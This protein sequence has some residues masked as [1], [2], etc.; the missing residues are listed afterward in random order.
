MISKLKKLDIHYHYCSEEMVARLETKMREAG[1]ELDASDNQRLS[2]H[3]DPEWRYVA[4]G[5]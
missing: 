1:G 3:Y 5:E 4:V 2:P